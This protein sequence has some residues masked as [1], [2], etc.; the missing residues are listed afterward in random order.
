[1][2]YYK[3]TTDTISPCWGDKLKLKITQKFK[4]MFSC[5]LKFILP[6]GRQNMTT[7]IA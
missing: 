3:N 6:I 2:G 7:S 1:M 5:G 4:A